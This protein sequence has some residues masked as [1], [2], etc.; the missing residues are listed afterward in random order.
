MRARNMLQHKCESDLHNPCKYRPLCLMMLD[1]LTMDLT[2]V[3]TPA[4]PFR[5]D[6]RLWFDPGQ[7]CHFRWKCER[8]TGCF[9]VKWVKMVDGSCGHRLASVHSQKGQEGFVSG[10]HNIRGGEM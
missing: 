1:L 9:V 10:R 7:A 4:L 5:V 6:L 8:L 3:A 2:L